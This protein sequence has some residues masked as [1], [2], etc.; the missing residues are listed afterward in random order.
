MTQDKLSFASDYMEGA[1][2][3]ILRRLAETNLEQTAGYGLDPHSEAARAAICRVCACPNAGIQFLVGGTQTNAV[4]IAGLLRPW[5]GVLAAQSGHIATHEAGAIEFTGHKVLPL[6]QTHGKLT[7]ADVEAACLTWRNDANHNHMVMPGMVYISQPTESG[8]LYSLAELTALSEVCRRYELPLYVDGARLAYA[9]SAPQ[10]DVSLADLARLA[11]AFYIGG[12][13]CGALF[14]EAVVL[15]DPE[16]IPHFFTLIKQ[17]GA[18]LAKGRITGIQFE[19]LFADTD[20]EPLYLHIGDSAV[21][22]AA[23]LQDALLAKGYALPQRSPT[24]QV[25]VE[26]PDETLRRLSE[27]IEYSF[28]EKSAPDRTVIRFATSWATRSETVEQLIDLL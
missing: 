11:D 6:P 1:H 3:E 16:R 5:Q 18:L 4:V 24:N 15:P 14:G 8:T 27:H 21:A 13:K 22:L 25:F 7:A 10:N 9:L 12:T 20:G 17:R 23:K 26:M 19:A 2:P 28:W